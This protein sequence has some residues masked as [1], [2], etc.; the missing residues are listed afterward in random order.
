L[1]Q[2]QNRKELPANPLMTEYYFFNG[3]LA[4]EP[5]DDI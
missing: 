5:A 1:V 3:L 4:T 2:T